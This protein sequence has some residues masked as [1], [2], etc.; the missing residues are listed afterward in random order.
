MHRSLCICGLLPRLATRTRV[1]VVLHQL[2]ACKPTNTG[3]LAARCLENSAVVY[4][5]RA[6]GGGAANPLEGPLSEL[7]LEAEPLLLYPHPSATPLAAWRSAPRPITLIV[8]DGTW[9]QTVRTCRR[10]RA[11]AE[12]ACVSLPAPEVAVDRLRTSARPDRLATLE[13]VALALGILEGPAVRD[14]LMR[15][16]RIMTERTLWTNGRVATADVTGGI[17]AGVRS[18]DPLK[19]A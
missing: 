18:H 9:P 10:L 3:A 13:A 6:P 2:E 17:P 16:Y 12:L 14:A 19:L 5:G 7:S 4:R 8:P 11:R 1:V 15:V